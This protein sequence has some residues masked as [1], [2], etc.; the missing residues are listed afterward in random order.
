[1]RLDAYNR[2]RRDIEARMLEAAVATGGGTA[3]TAV[4]GFAAAGNWP[5]RGIGVVA[6]RPRGRYAG[7]ARGGGAPDG[8]RPGSGPPVPRLAARP[9]GHRGAPSRP[10]A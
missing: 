9:G 4:L 6:A 8:T 1:A 3:Q 5:P 2:E 7:P 10:V